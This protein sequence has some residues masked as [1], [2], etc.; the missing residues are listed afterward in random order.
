[1]KNIIITGAS[2]GI[3][4]EAVLAFAAK[5]AKKIL[6]IARSQ[7]NLDALKEQVNSKFPN[8]QILTYSLD[9]AIA[10]YS[11]LDTFI[12]TE[13]ESIDILVNNA[14]HLVAKPFIEMTDDDFDSQMTI[15][16]KS[17][18]KL[19]QICIPL[20]SNPSHIVNI[21]S[22]GGVQGSVKFPG[23]SLYSAAKG[24]VSILTESM[25]A[26]LSEKGISVN[27][28]AFGAVNTDMLRSAFP[29]Y[30]A[31]ITAA[32]MGS[33]LADFAWSQGK[34]YNGKVLPVSNSTP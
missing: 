3:G 21:S 4:K 5:G 25:A 13:F 32:E 24:A 18:F 17:V 15:N 7:E 26:E 29:D 33:F 19:S 12:K 8:S 22:M 11:G 16:A 27:A 30:K 2:R 9:L 1:M 34:F 14:G 6:A 10:D 20:L 28:L 31:P 23:L